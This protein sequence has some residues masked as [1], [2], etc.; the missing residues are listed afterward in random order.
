MFGVWE[1]LSDFWARLRFGNNNTGITVTSD[2]PGSM[3]FRFAALGNAGSPRPWWRVLFNATSGVEI[4]SATNENFSD[5]ANVMS[6]GAQTNVNANVDA[7]GL[8]LD[9]A[10]LDGSFK[11]RNADG[12]ATLGAIR[13]VGNGQGGFQLIF[14]ARNKTGQMI[15]MMALDADQAFDGCMA[16]V[17]GGAQHRLRRAA[18][19]TATLL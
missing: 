11:I 3:E 4:Q 5:A 15:D 18:D 8:N 16:I 17:A 19:G 14:S 12:T 1:K 10:S 9:V 2:G 7:N 6:F 13:A